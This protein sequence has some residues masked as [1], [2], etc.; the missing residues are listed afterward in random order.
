MAETHDWRAVYDFWFPLDLTDADLPTHWKML[1]WWMRG[2]A[3]AELAP[4]RPV[5]DAARAGHLDHWLETPR[6]RL[7]LI[8]V[9]DQFTRGLLAGTP[10]T[11]AS[12]AEALQIAEE[13]LKNGHYEALTNN[14]ERFFFLMPT[15][16]AEGTDHLD[17][18]DRIIDLSEKAMDDVPAH[19]LPIYQFSL[20]QAHGHRDVIARFGRFPHRNALLGR[21]STPEE[22]AYLEKGDYVYNRQPPQA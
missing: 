3:S 22:M 6:G 9:L 11:Y 17:R 14:W 4:F 10:E 20:S 18:L 8:I 1:T 15:A 2:G 5:L 19:L 16:H 21:D 12:D 7:S 13:G